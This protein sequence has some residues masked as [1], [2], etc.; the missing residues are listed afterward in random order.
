MSILSDKDIF[1]LLVEK[2][3][4]ISPLEVS[5]I[6]P[7]SVDLRLGGKLE[8]PHPGEKLLLYPGAEKPSPR[9]T[10]YDIEK[11][12]YT[13]KPGEVVYASTLEELEIPSFCNA[14]IYNKNS[15]ALAGLHVCSG[16]YINPGY[17][18]VMPLVLKNIG[19]YELVIGAGMQICQL[20]LSKLHTPAT[21]SYPDRYNEQ[22][23]AQLAQNLGVDNTNSPQK[24]QLSLFLEKRIQELASAK[25]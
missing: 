16:S 1:S 14:K 9:Y 15:L 17:K 24:S 3:L 21:R 11:E 20:E 12:H 10:D 4:V 25:S 13:L 5:Q 23:L 6:Q 19:V 18:G 8:I 22:A 7:A 2:K